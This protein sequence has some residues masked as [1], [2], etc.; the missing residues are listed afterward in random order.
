[1]TADLQR[2]VISKMTEDIKAKEG[3]TLYT[4][5]DLRS[6]FK[7]GKNRAY[8]IMHMKGFPAIKVCG[9]YYVEKNALENWIKKMMQK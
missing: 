6:I 9:S 1:M 4:A 7:C 5:L 3:I 2:E 8:E